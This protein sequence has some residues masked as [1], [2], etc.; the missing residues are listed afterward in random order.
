[1][2]L[3]IIAELFK[4]AFVL[5]RCYLPFW[6]PLFPLRKFYAEQMLVLLGIKRNHPDTQLEKRFNWWKGYA[7]YTYRIN[8]GLL[9][10]REN[11]IS[12]HNCAPQRKHCWQLLSTDP[13]C[14]SYLSQV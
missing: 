7:I 10:V 12:L 3:K 14:K 13:G 11:E 1:M 8:F 6:Q 5:L 9:E 4:N 2:S